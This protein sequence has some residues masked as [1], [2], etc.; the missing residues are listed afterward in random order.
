MSAKIVLVRHGQT[1]WSRDGRHTGRTDIGLTDQGRAE[2]ALVAPTLEGWKFTKVFSSPLSRALDTARLA[3]IGDGIVIDDLLVEWDYGDVEGRTNDEIQRERPGWSKWT[4]SA[5]EGGETATDV[6][7]RADAAIEQLMSTDDGSVLVF[8]HGH[9]LAVLIARWLGL[10]ATEGRRFILQ[11]A[12]ASQLGH[13]RGDRV[14]KTLNHRCGQ[15][16][17]P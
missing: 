13:K 9:F 1:E 11:T 17:A 10:A 8:A 5:I 7:S 16:L 2:A 4:A 3:G 14:L 15:V 12:T 6:G